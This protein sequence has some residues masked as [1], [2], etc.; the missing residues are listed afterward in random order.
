MR[1]DGLEG[2]GF[3]LT[4][5]DGAAVDADAVVLATPAM[6]ASKLLGGLDPALSDRLA[7]I[8]YVSTAVVSFG[9]RGASLPRPLDGFGFVIPGK[10]RRRITGCTWSSSKFENRAAH[11]SALVRC[12]LGGATDQSSAL[13][14]EEE[15]VRVAR[16]ELRD[17]MGITADPIL[18]DVRRWKDSHPQYDVG[19][20]DRLAE[21]ELLLARHPGL[22]LAG[23]SY[24]GVGLPDCI[25]SGAL[26]SEAILKD[27]R[28]KE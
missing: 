6:D 26:A 5:E 3:R 13:L 23:S 20:L 7:A 17:L 16:E 11:G 10:E 21:M 4:L 19:H 15:M 2:G 18:I 12:F 25:H 27:R 8:R 24:R 22:H 9:Y 1:L 28:R 14:P